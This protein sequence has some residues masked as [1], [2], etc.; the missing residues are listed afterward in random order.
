MNYI[1]LTELKNAWIFKHKNLPITPQDIAAIKPM[2]ETRARVLWDTFISK[3]VDHPDF[4]RQGDWPYNQSNWLDKGNWGG[5]WDSNETSLPAVISEHLT[6]EANT[7][8]YFSSARQQ[9]I[10][11][12]WQVFQR[13]WKN[14]LFINDGV[15][16]VAKKRREAV[17]FLANGSFKVGNRVI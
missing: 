14:F 16:L 7:I 11:T 6:W 15:I 1:P 3:Q 12:T 10:E 8:V 13:C 5:L 4:F 9:V 17:Q 2:S